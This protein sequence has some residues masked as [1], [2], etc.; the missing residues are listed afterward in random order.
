MEKVYIIISRI[1]THDY[2][3]IEIWDN[4]KLAKTKIKIIYDKELE[5]K[6][7][8]KKNKWITKLKV[9]ETEDCYT[10]NWVNSDEEKRKFIVYYKEI[11]IKG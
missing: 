5:E 11:E 7:G 8:W 2:F 1:N 10:I 3:N 4:E 6:K 9:Y